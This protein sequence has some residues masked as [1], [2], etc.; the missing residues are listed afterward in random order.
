M[1]DRWFKADLHVHSYHSGQTKHLRLIRPRDCYSDP[2]DVYRTAKKRGMDLVTLT[3]HDSIDGCLAVLERWRDLDDFII[4]EEVT[5]YVPEFDHSMHIG[6]F[7]I[8]EVQ[9]REIQRLRGNA[10]DL[11]AYLEQNRILH[12]LNHFFHDFDR[13]EY[14][15]DYV[16]HVI[17]LFRVF[18]THNGAMSEEHNRLVARLLK[19]FAGEQKRYGVLGGSDAHTLRRIGTTYTASPARTKEEFLEDIRQG[20]A[21]ACGRH[22]DHWAIAADIYGVVLRYYPSVLKNRHRDYAFWTRLKNILVSFSLSPFLFLPYVI[23]V[24]HSRRER[25]RVREIH[26]QLLGKLE[27][28]E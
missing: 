13:L 6:V 3:D 7:N 27:R 19:F 16:R 5:A 26:R 2:L 9:H 22:A 24:R 21:F 1:S 28:M 12:A 10:A 15:R 17:S 14:L 11:V 4:S 25:Q 18:E 20:R 23:A 8:T